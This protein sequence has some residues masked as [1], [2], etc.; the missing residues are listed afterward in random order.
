M[1]AERGQAMGVTTV[2][3]AGPAVAPAC[4]SQ[5]AALA[6]LGGMV[7]RVAHDLGNLLGPVELYATLLGEQCGSSPDLAPLSGRLLLGVQQLRG[8]A[9]NLLAVA[10]RRRPEWGPADLGQIALEAVETARLAVR[11]TGIAVRSRLA[12]PKAIVPGDGGQLRRAIQN[13]V[14]NAIQAMPRGGTLTIGLR[15]RDGAAELVVRDTGVGMDAETLRRAAEPFFTTRP[16]G[17]GLGLAIVHEV[18]TVH[19]AGFHIRSRPNEGTTARLVVPGC[20]MTHA[21]EEVLA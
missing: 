18:A 16:Q 12:V 10:H 4:D 13:L 2:G 5:L 6:T 15:L 19:G 11:G 8:L 21:P 20:D 17:T 9:G 1:V 14:L 7:A 3:D